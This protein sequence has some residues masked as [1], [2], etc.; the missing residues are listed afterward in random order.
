MEM[1]RI[2]GS[3]FTTYSKQELYFILGVR[4]L[5]AIFAKILTLH[6]SLQM[7]TK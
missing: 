6:V 7:S 1:G 3:Q 2:L 5:K 4:D